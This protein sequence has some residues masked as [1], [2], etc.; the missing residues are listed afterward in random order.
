M[1]IAV[2]DRFVRRQDAARASE[3]NT[4]AADTGYDTAVISDGSG[5]G[6][7]GAG[8]TDTTRVDT[9]GKYLWIGDLGQVN[10]SLSNRGVG[11]LVP[12]VDSVTQEPVGLASHR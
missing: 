4:T 3:P 2:G 6:T 10:D 8:E 1:A 7:W 11:T 9:A 5:Y 12:V